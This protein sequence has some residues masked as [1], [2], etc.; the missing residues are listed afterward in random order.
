MRRQPARLRPRPTPRA[1]SYER[2]RSRRFTCQCGRS[3][4]PTDR[5]R[6]RQAVVCCFSCRGCLVSLLLEGSAGRLSQRRFSSGVN[7]VN[8]S[9]SRL[10]PTPELK[11]DLAVGFD[12]HDR[13]SDL[14]TWHASGLYFVSDRAIVG[15]D[16]RR[17]ALLAV[18]ARPE[19]R[20]FN[21]VMDL[22]AVGPGFY[23]DVYRGIVELAV[24]NEHG[25]R[26]EAGLEKLQDGNRRRFAYVHLQIP[27]TS[28]ARTWAAIRPNV[29]FETFRDHQLSY[30]SP[31]RHL[32]IG[33]MLHAIRR[34]A[35]WQNRIGNQPAAAVYRWRDR[36][37]STRR[38][39]RWRQAGGNV[40]ERRRIRILGRSAGSSAVAPWRAGQ[41]PGGTVTRL[42]LFSSAGLVTLTLAC[43]Q[44]TPPDPSRDFRQHSWDAYKRIYIRAEGNVVD[45]DRNGGGTTSE[46][47]GYAMLRAVWMRDEEAFN[48]TFRWTEQ[49]LKRPDGLYSWLWTPADGGKILDANTAADADQEIAFA[50][51]LGSQV[52]QDPQMLVSARQILL[53]I[54]QNERVE[55][56]PRWFPAAGNWAVSQRIVN[57]SYFVP[58]AYPYFAR[59]DPE[60]RWET[61]TESGYDL[62]AKSLGMGAARLIPDFMSITRDGNPDAL[63]QG[64]ELSS[65]FSSDAMRI[66]WR[67]AV[68]CRLH[69][70]TRACADPL[71][72]GQLTAMLARDGVL[73]TR[74][75]IDGVR[76]RAGRI[77]QLLRRGS[78]FSPASR[79]PCRTRRQKEPP[80]AITAGPDRGR[81][82][83]ILRRKLDLVRPCRR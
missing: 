3:E 60:G 75:G 2:R 38:A 10:F 15:L 83:P 25:A 52:F 29:F 35:G 76:S 62:I 24:R 21:R 40:V 14:I 71:G 82:E 53:A 16:A 23:G 70:R 28:T 42:A 61:V 4:I 18:N 26:A 27:T 57:L 67:V 80:L 6:L 59:I 39:E 77:V 33:T 78:S 58:Y 34:Y 17:E 12:Q 20:Q 63:P 51:V 47:Q 11:I 66:Y 55:V 43:G 48:R 81:T 41:H 73:F 37:W 74:Y 8:L 79:P 49:H 64:T 19:L 31:R 54:R 7:S 13:A 32:T 45:P 30:F 72:A 65:D 69:S 9:V 1:V 56:G 44:M 22:Q 36:S 50:L 68:D 5:G 46:G